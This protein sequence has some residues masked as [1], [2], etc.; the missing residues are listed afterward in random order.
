MVVVL[1]LPLAKISKN[2]YLESKMWSNMAQIWIRGE[3][4]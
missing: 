2:R 3:L 4:L 1:N